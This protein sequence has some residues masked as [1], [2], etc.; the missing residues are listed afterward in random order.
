MPSSTGFD[1]DGAAQC[2]QDGEER[3]RRAGMSGTSVDE[4][5]LR[6]DDGIKGGRSAKRAV[7]RTARPA[8]TPSAICP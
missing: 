7:I 8:R 1:Q 5:S 3:N 6:P 4:Q 2:E